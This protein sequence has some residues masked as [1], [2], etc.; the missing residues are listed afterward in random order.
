MRLVFRSE[1]VIGLFIRTE[2]LRMCKALSVCTSFEARGSLF[3]RRDF[4]Q[5]K[6]RE[7]ALSGPS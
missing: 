2:T 5:M 1:N 6:A 3:N 4:G 7:R